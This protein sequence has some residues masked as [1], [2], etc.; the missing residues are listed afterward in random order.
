MRA[1][2]EHGRIGSN[3][4]AH[5]DAR[6]AERAAALAQEGADYI[7]RV[8]VG[9]RAGVVAAHLR[10]DRL[11]RLTEQRSPLRARLRERPLAERGFEAPLD[12]RNRRVDPARAVDEEHRH[13]AV[14]R[15]AL[16]RVGKE[17]T[18][19]SPRSSSRARW[20]SGVGISQTARER[21]STAAAGSVDP[22]AIT[23]GELGSAS[24]SST[25]IGPRSR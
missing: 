25:T 17:Q 23:S 4:D 7:V 5:I 1:V 21:S 20:N 19:G 9:P 8:S 10:Y 15:L 3:L 2:R 6:V 24:R 16:D 13:A 22:S 11:V 14:S 18:R 12:G